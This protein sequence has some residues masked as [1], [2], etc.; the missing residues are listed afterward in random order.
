MAA[1]NDGHVNRLVVTTHE[2]ILLEHVTQ[3]C[4]YGVNCAWGNGPIQCQAWI[5]N[6]QLWP[7]RPWPGRSGSSI[8]LQ[9]HRQPAHRP[10]PNHVGPAHAGLR[11]TRT[12]VTRE[13][14]IGYHALWQQVLKSPR[15]DT[16]PSGVPN[17]SGRPSDNKGEPTPAIGNVIRVIASAQM[18]VPTFIEVSAQADA[19]EILEELHT[20]CPRTDL[21]SWQLM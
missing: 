14:P 16:H 7:N 8:Y 1:M 11:Q 15:F 17:L 5:Q 3:S 12:V 10:P 9:V 13:Q 19:H 2:H 6:V 4:G 18:E 21:T 20:W